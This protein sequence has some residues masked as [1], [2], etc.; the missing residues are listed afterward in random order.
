MQ[1]D[2]LDRNT[3]QFSP[4][5]QWVNIVDIGIGLAQITMDS[6]WIVKAN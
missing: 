4:V 5:Y 1:S 6:I 3:S 2:Q